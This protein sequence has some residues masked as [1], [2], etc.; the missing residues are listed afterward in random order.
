MGDGPVQ[1]SGA[2]A[3]GPKNPT[4]PQLAAKFGAVPGL[5]GRALCGRDRAR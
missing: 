4:V 3:S 1:Y 2:T 5:R